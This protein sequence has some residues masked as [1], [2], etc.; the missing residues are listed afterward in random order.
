M[1]VSVM[2][3]F[4]SMLGGVTIFAVLGNLASITKTEDLSKVFAGT[5][6]FGLAFKIYPEAISKIATK[7][8]GDGYL[9]QVSCLC[10]FN[11]HRNDFSIFHR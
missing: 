1:I 4:T 7:I 3:T 10:D 6:G 11:S 5:S 2:D 9:P 8:G